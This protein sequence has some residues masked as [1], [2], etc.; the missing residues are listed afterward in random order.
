MS[1]GPSAAPRLNVQK[2]IRYSSTSKSNGTSDAR[3][4][5]TQRVVSS[6]N[7]NTA[8]LNFIEGCSLSR[9]ECCLQNEKKG[10]ANTLQLNTIKTCQRLLSSSWP[11]PDGDF[12]GLLSPPSDTA[13]M[14]KLSVSRCPRTTVLVSDG[15]RAPNRSWRNNYLRIVCIQKVSHLQILLL[16]PRPDTLIVGRDVVHHRASMFLC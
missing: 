10:R 6:L 1:D 4:L 7:I 16:N 12:C 13:S 8:L 2:Q 5:L 14:L 3:N 9:P 11:Q 15:A